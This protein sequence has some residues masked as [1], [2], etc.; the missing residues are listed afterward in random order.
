MLIEDGGV[1]FRAPARID[2][3]GD[4]PTAPAPAAPRQNHAPNDG[5]DFPRQGPKE[6]QAPSC[7]TA[8]STPADVNLWWRSMS[9]EQRERE[10]QS[11]PKRI[12]DMN[13]VPAAD[14]DKANRLSL[15]QQKADLARQED[16]ARKTL[17]SIEDNPST[18]PE[19][20]AQALDNAQ[21]D[22]DAIASK[23]KQLDDSER[24]L[25]ELGDRGYLLG[26]DAAGDGRAIIAV[27]NPDTAKHTAVWVPGLGTDL[28]STG[29]N[30]DRVKNLQ[31]AADKLT[32]E[33]DDVAAI[34]WLGYDAPETD[35]L[36]VAGTARSKDGGAKLDGF[37]DGLRATHQGGDYH[38]TAVGHSY[39]STVVAEAALNGNGL[40]VD[41][42]VVAGSPGM[43]TDN[44][45]NLQING[46]ED[47]KHVW[48]GSA[49]NDPVSDFS[50]SKWGWL[51]WLSPLGAAAYE[52]GHG[53]S[54][55]RG[56]FG[57][58]RYQVDTEG[59][60]AYW[61]K[62]SKSL[63]NQAHIVVGNYRPVGLEHG[64]KPED[65]VA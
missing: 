36:S 60:S 45:R 7:P 42:I 13:G 41:D 18:I 63:D 64:N 19:Q 52:H 5:V 31:E 26:I 54:P 15:Q 21:R 48:A 51:K 35:N 49:K 57:A 6:L 9:A 23:R 59:H 50:G 65:W 37:V 4:A 25:N 10:I 56:D 30:V 27:G 47:S 14:R 3:T 34:M 22:V 33:K 17:N 58:N 46:C 24:K 44:A 32:G 53:Q 29:G 20:Q 28:G 61:N 62:D 1:R 55:H 11:N 39:G 38:I 16:E 43:H 12:G 8:N 40:A 2:A